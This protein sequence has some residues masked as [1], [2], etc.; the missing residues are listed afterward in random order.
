LLFEAG[1]VAKK[2]GLARV[3]PYL[4]DELPEAADRSP[5]GQF[6]AVHTVSTVLPNRISETF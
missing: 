5:L 6:Q 3:V 1:A 2:F 4:I